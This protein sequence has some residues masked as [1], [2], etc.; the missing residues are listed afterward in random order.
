MKGV[1]AVW[2]HA[3]DELYHGQRGPAAN[4]NVLSTAHSAK[5]GT[6]AHEPMTWVIPYGKG[7]CVTMVMG[8]QG[9]GQKERPALECVGFQTIFA[10]AVEWAATQNVTIPI[11]DEF[12][13]A[14]EVSIERP[15]F[16]KKRKR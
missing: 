16:R 5:R 8:H 15:N 13:S 12:P 2:M 6:G 11:P 14:T 3:Q 9:H 1:P 7:R 10:R 4:M